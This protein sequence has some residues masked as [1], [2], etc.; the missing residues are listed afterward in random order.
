[1][2]GRG[3][4]TGASPDLASRIGQQDRDSRQNAP[5][6]RVMNVHFAD[7]GLSTYTHVSEQHSTFGTK[8]IVPTTR[9]AHY[10]PMSSL[11]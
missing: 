6:A 8:V 10:V 11:T 3:G 7:Q 5:A 4:P 9:E 2:R 1:M